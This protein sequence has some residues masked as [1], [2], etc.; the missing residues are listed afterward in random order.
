MGDGMRVYH[1]SYAPI[2]RA[3]G[4][5]DSANRKSPS[6]VVMK[7]RLMALDFV[8]AHMGFHY[9]ESEAEKIAFFRRHFGAAQEQLPI[10]PY[11]VRRRQGDL[12]TRYFVEKFPIFIVEPG[13][14]RKPMIGFSFIDD[15]HVTAA[16]FV[17]FLSRYRALAALIPRLQLFYISA[18]PTKV[19]LA[20]AQF[21]RHWGGGSR[22]DVPEA[23]LRSTRQWR[24]EWN[25]GPALE[26]SQSD[27]TR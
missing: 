4:L 18:L 10:P 2:Y 3:L 14:E 27:R 9:L 22:P 13:A 7:S 6:E 12:G 17:N 21:E 5:E 15:G 20:K 23:M 1:L 16:G 11:R 25:V 8:L 26:W 19:E 24:E